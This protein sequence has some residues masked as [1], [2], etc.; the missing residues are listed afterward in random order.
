[1]LLLNKCFIVAAAAAAAAVVVVVVVV[2][3]VY[4]VIDSVQK[5]LDTPSYMKSYK[6]LFTI[7]T[8]ASHHNL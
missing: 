6:P 1:V 4:F 5:L 8:L 3:V 2:V 7:S